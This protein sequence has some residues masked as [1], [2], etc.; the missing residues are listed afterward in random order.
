MRLDYGSDVQHVDQFSLFFATLHE[1]VARFQIF[2][3]LERRIRIINTVELVASQ[4]PL[5]LGL[6]FS[7]CILNLSELHAVGGNLLVN[8]LQQFG[9]SWPVFSIFLDTSENDCLHNLLFSLVNNSC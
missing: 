2:F 4:D 8:Q 3:I 6:P 1:K 9:D 5:Q 7:L